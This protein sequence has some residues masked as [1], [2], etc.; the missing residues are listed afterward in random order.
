MKLIGKCCGRSI[1]KK[2]LAQSAGSGNAKTNIPQGNG[3]ATKTKE[4]VKNALLA[5]WKMGCLGNALYVPCWRGPA[6]FPAK[7]QRAQCAFYRVTA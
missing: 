2:S 1:W 6:E 3:N 7:H 4:Y 5:M